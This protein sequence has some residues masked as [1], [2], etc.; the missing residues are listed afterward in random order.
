MCSRIAFCYHLQ[1]H[2]NRR[3]SGLAHTPLYVI[4]KFAQPHFPNMK[5]K[6]KERNLGWQRWASNPRR[7]SRYHGYITLQLNA[8]IH[9]TTRVISSHIDYLTYIVNSTQGCESSGYRIEIRQYVYCAQYI[10]DFDSTCRWSEQSNVL[11]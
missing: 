9:W 5:F 4:H 3:Y 11:V 6:K 1:L 2:K 8:P 10:I 7:N